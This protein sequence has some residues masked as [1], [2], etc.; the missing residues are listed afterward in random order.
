MDIFKWITLIIVAS[1]MVVL[2]HVFRNFF[3]TLKKSRKKRIGY[4]PETVLIVPCRGIDKH[5]EQNIRAYLTQDYGNYRVWFV[6]DAQSDP[7]YDKLHQLKTHYQS[8][9]QAKQIDIKVAGPAAGCSQ[10][11]HNLLF[12]C[13][14]ITH[15]IQMIAFADSDAYT[16]RDWLG[17]LIFPLR[18]EKI[19]LATGYRWFIPEQLNLASIALSALNAKV[20]QL[21]G[22]NRFN[23]AWGGS[24]AMRYD[25]FKALDI[26]SLWKNVLSDDLSL[27]HA[28]KKT[29]RKIEFVPACLVAS[30]ESMTWRSLFEFVRRQFIITRIYT[31]AF[32][33][34]GLLSS[35]LSVVALWLPLGLAVNTALLNGAGAA[36]YAICAGSV[37]AA[38]CLRA[39]CRQTM[40]MRLF[41]P[42]AGRIKKAAIADIGFFWGWSLLMLIMIGSSAFGR[43]I[44]W[45]K[46]KYKLIAPDHIEIVKSS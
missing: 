21:L 22:N 3:Y 34:F 46:I 2:I 36:F 32:W 38:Q 4:A 6:V 33:L 7:A 26:E 1:Q 20:A 27:T 40:A 42:Y 31:P 29:S 12:C 13:Q 25:L 15:P 45:R 11:I 35:V 14:Q 30:F 9:S 44:S 23:H 24:M 43:I 19:G 5:F 8:E 17:H 37:I 10:K 41:E 16:R 18:R 39:G 28:I